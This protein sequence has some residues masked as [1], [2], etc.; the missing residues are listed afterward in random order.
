[1]HNAEKKRWVVKKEKVWFKPGSGRFDFPL[2]CGVPAPG[3]T[4]P[5][6]LPDFA[7]AWQTNN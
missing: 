5:I 2:A 6:A 3:P 7:A 4:S 1:L